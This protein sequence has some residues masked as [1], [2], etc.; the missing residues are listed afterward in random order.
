MRFN[1]VERSAKDD[2]YGKWEIDD[3]RRPRLT[4]KHLNKMRKRRAAAEA[5]HATEAENWR[6]MYA[7]AQGE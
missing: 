6:D 1:E 2:E 4:L 3:T 5:E 7:Q